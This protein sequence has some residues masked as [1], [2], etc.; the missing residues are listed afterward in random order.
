M[1]HPDFS[2]FKPIMNSAG[3]RPLYGNQK[4]PSAHWVSAGGPSS[5]NRTAEAQHA[6]VAAREQLFG[7]ASRCRDCKRRLP[8][9]RAA[10]DADLKPGRKE[11][12]ARGKSG[13]EPAV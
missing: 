5:S 8:T 4:T 11:V 10:R 2:Q 1:P 7:G 6:G 3:L 12:P 9:M 13:L